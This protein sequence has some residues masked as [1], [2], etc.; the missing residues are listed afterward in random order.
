MDAGTSYTDL[1]AKVARIARGDRRF[2]LSLALPLD[3]IT[4]DPRFTDDE[5]MTLER[6]GPPRDWVPDFVR[7]LLSQPRP[8]KAER[9][10]P[11]RPDHEHADPDPDVERL[12]TK[13]RERIEQDPIFA[14]Q[15]RVDPSRAAMSADFL[16]PD[17]RRLAA[18]TDPKRWAYSRRR[19]TRPRPNLRRE[20]MDKV[21]A[22]ARHDAG[23]ARLLL[24][25]PRRAVCKA[26]WLDER[27]EQRGR[28]A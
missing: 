14:D 28:L 8:R 26:V 20:A 13:V 11:R 27:R 9:A 10:S 6:G 16:A 25:D 12:R 4:L 23:F 1:L 18:R 22:H 19:W 21:L 17:E 7:T 2:A 24:R 15:I 5:R 3:A